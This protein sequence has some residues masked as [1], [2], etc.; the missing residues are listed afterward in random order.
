MILDIAAH[1]AI[2]LGALGCQRC[3]QKLCRHKVRGWVIIAGLMLGEATA[4]VVLIG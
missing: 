2:G 4:S 1:L 3:G